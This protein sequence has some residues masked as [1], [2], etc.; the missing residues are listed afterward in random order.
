MQNRSRDYRVGM[1]VFL[2]MVILGVLII[3]YGEQPTWLWTTKWELSVL[4]DTPRGVEEGTPAFLQGVQVGRVNEIM[5]QD[6]KQPNLGA[7]VAIEIDEEF[8]IPTDSVAELHSKFAFDKGA[9]H[10]LPPDKP[11]PPFKKDGSARIRGKMVGPLETLIPE[12]YIGD[13][14]QAVKEIGKFGTVADDLHDLLMITPVEIVD[15]PDGNAIANLHTFIQR[16]DQTTKL[17]NEIFSD[18]GNQNLKEAIANIK[19]ASE[20]LTQWTAKLEDRTDQL[21]SQAGS[22]M[23]TVEQKINQLAGSLTST[24]GDISLL[25]DELQKMAV[26]INSGEGTAGQL[27]HDPKFYEELLVTLETFQQTIEEVT[28]LTVQLQEEGLIKLN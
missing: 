7:A 5:L 21:T 11:H 14:N 28:R 1:F 24:L 3:I 12:E 9:V 8:E 18:G 22:T 19:T 20:Q 2:G 25:L 27:V 4:V 15:D 26:A 6:P 23:K 10:I 13:L 16:I 17:V